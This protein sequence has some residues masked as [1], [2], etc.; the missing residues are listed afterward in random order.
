MMTYRVAKERARND[1]GGFVAD[2]VIR[3]NFV[4]ICGGLVS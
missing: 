3:V 2:I 1:S 4:E